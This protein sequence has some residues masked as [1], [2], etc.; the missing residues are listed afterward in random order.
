MKLP[1]TSIQ[2]RFHLVGRRVRGVEWWFTKCIGLVSRNTFHGS[3]VN[4]P[5]GTILHGALGAELCEGSGQPSWS[6][7][8]MPIPGPSPLREAC[9]EYATVDKSVLESMSLGQ[10]CS[11]EH[12]SSR[13]DE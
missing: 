10:E 2:F 9:R 7:C 1:P 12:E 13:T 11:G 8:A 5:A 4:V 3:E 6:A